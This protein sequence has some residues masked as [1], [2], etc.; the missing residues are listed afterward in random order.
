MVTVRVELAPE[1]IDVGENVTCAPVGAPV[2]LRATVWGLPPVTA[3]EI[4]PV[5]DEPATTD[6]DDGVAVIEKS[7][8]A[9][10]V[11]VKVVVSVV[12]VP[13]P[14]TVIG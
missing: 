1:V 11:R 14:V 10:T 7:G 4:V 8:S 5:V 12:A 2:E 9:V 6:A 3:V 13:V